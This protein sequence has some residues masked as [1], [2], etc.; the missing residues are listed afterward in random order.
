MVIGAIISYALFLVSL[1]VPNQ[2]DML[3]GAL[4]AIACWLIPGIYLRSRY[5]KMKAHVP[6]A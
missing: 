1:F 2:Y 3:C 4:A 5:Q 6:G